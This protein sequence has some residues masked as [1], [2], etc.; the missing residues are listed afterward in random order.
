MADKPDLFSRLFRKTQDIKKSLE[1]KEKPAP[2]ARPT[3]AAKPQGSAGKPAAKEN[4]GTE[5]KNKIG[6]SGSKIELYQTCP[7]KFHFTYIR[8]VK[9]PSAPSPHLSFDQTLHTTLGKYYKNKRVDEPFRLDRLF[10]ILDESWDP[11]GYEDGE[12]ALDYRHSAESAFRLYFERYCQTPPRHIEVDYF[13]K[14]DLAGGEY[15]GKIDRVDRH[16]D[17][18]LELI[19]YK[20]GKPPYGGV[21]EL[22]Q[23]LAVQL[24]FVATESIWP[25]KVKK[26]TF[27]YLKDG[28]SLSV[29]RNKAEMALAE[30]RYLDIGEAI[31]Q[32]NFQPIR[33]A[34][35]GFC[36]FQDLCPVGQIPTLNASKIRS[37]LDCPHKYAAIYVKHQ[38]PKDA[39]E[40]PSFDLALDR[41]LHDALAQFH[42]DYRPTPN[43]GPESALYT[44]LF[45]AIPAD[46]PEEMQDQIKNTGREYL[47]NYL[48][49]FFPKSKTWLVNEFIEYNTE[50]FC[51]QTTVDRID[52][53]SAGN[54]S[55]IDYKTGKRMLTAAELANDPVTAAVCAAAEQRWPGKVKSFCCIYLR[56]GEEVRLEITDMLIRKGNQLLHSIGEQIRQ[57]NFEPLGGPV[58]STCPV[59]GICGEKRLVVSMSKIQTLRDCPKRYEFRYISKAP[60][61]DKEKPAIVLYQLLQSMLQEY[62]GAG[63]LQD[64]GLLL[65]KAAARVNDDKTLSAPA[66]QDVLTKAYTAFQNINEL[67]KSGFP[68]VHS[69]GEQAR[70]GFEDLVLTTRFDRIDLLPNGNLHVIIYKTGKKA[71]TPHEARLDLSGV[72]NWFIADR[73]YPGRIDRVSYVYLL[74]GDVIPFTPSDQDIEKL[75]LTFSEFVRENQ[76]AEFEGHRNPLCPYCDYIDQ[77]EDAKSM[78]LSPSKIN[79][80]TSCALKYQMK[81]ID[82]VPKEARPTPNLSFDRSIHFALREFHENYESG[83]F[84]KNP[85]R[86]ILNKYWITD[87][88]SDIE[89][90][91]R[92]KIRANM[93]LEEYFKGLNGH[94]NPVMFEVAV[95]WSW[96]GVD[97]VVQV[98]RIDQLPDGRYEIIDYK[99]GKK[100][101]DERVINEDSSLM[102]MYLAA[103]QKW[104]G[105]IAKVSYHFL[106]NNKRYSLEPSE[107]DVVSHKTKMAELVTLINKNEFEAKKG[108][109]CAWCEYYGPCPEW[110]IKPHEMAGE[111]PEQFRQ[112]I[113]LSYSKMSLYLNCPRSY[114][115]LYIDKV[116][117]KPQPF[118]SFGTTIHETFE[119]VYD[120]VNPIPKPTL[121]QVLD[122]YDEVRLTHREGFDSDATEMQYREDGIRQIT[123]YYNSFIKDAEFKPAYS[124][125]DY[126]EIPC[127]KYAVMT[128]FIDRIDK[129]DDGT[130][131]ILDYKTEPTMR[132]QEAVDTDKQLSI[133]YWACEDTLGLKISKL[134]LLMLDHDVKVETTRTRD[135]IPKVIETI[136]KTAYEMIHEKDFLPRKNKYCKSC[137]HL[138]DCPMRPEVEADESLIS[139]KKF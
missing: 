80:F 126:F 93:M 10:A 64:A 117:P 131:E 20:S 112:R 12:Q 99:T 114:K 34:A 102:N 90:E 95:K 119:R 123:R 25:G 14:I 42:R 52:N 77:C 8:K 130:F 23:S 9:K 87:G 58:C 128:G 26:M 136:D 43:R 106:A 44:L 121:Q 61:P 91:E 81:Y 79:C 108:A 94:E 104:P 125:E 29:T 1:Q 111:T 127:G 138:H 31:Y 137:D 70:V 133:Y 35:C 39:N 75:K 50:H 139:M 55:L 38:K 19:D 103:N 66:R 118:F 33:S 122:I 7:K 74:T 109:L 78:L 88:Y 110:K 21:T 3:P 2:V 85:F 134:S 68:K 84:K 32:G 71:M 83:Q 47:Q 115:K 18:T 101:P 6:L 107:A 45:K 17:G 89:E 73:V 113:R 76:D 135:S 62:A 98:D 105:K 22:E 40:P 65:E 129:L 24:M 13:F 72:Y 82:R 36:D 86:S 15:S 11:R 100:V 51:F 53:D 49:T 16:P 5:T 116:P 28:S 124:I 30:K 27:I 54:Y 69:L 46:L 132:T 63:R 37:F 120:P 57:K 97:T 48:N 41:P 60:V 96:N 4:Q 92:F 67:F 56:H 59:A